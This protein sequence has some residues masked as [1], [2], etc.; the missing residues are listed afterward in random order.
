VVLD[1]LLQ[2]FTNLN[3]AVGKSVL[4]LVGGLIRVL[5]AEL[6]YGGFTLFV[7]EVVVVLELIV[8]GSSILKAPRNYS[9]NK[10]GETI[11]IIDFDSGSL[12][13]AHS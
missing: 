9:F 4:F 13:V 8:S 10:N 1:S 5:C 11:L 7:H 2:M 6:T 3:L 12:K